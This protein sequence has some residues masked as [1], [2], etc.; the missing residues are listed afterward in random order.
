[1]KNT[2]K[3]MEIK[4]EERKIKGKKVKALRR[5]GLV[6]ANLFGGSKETEPLQLSLADFKRV[7]DKV[8][9]S[10][11]IDLNIGGKKEKALID[12][13][14]YDP[15]GNV[16]HV[17]FKRIEAGE[18]LTATV[19]IELQG[20]AP[21]VKEGRGILLTLLNE[22]E[23]ECLPQ[24][25]PSEIRIDITSLTEV[26]QEIKI[27]DLPIDQKKV[28]ILE[29]EPD[30]VVLKI[31]YP[32]MAEEEEP[33]PVSEGEAVAAVEAIKEKPEEK[34]EEGEDKEEEENG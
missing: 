20:E 30:D 5:Q 18:K 33:T 15:F 3:S 26:G 34:T 1:M 22:L 13:V 28:R 16:L 7:Y 23:V 8:G 17:D 32:E 19:A 24:D 29:H 6:P 12:E 25:L 9:E 14:Q 21:A 10:T 4:V 27:A 11:I 2:L 31:D